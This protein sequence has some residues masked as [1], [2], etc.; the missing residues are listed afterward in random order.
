MKT[1]PSDH[2]FFD[3]ATEPVCIPRIDRADET[4]H[5]IANENQLPPPALTRHIHHEHIH[6][7]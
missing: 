6:Q 2:W 1:S 3:I 7:R 5:R 4:I